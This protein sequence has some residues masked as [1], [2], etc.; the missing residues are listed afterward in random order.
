MEAWLKAIGTP[1]AKVWNEVIW[2]PRIE[3]DGDFAQVWAPFAFYLDTTLS[4]CGVDA[5]H[6]IR[7]GNGQWKIFHLAD[8]HR[9]NGCEIPKEVSDRIK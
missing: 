4:H 8:T 7:D 5:F 1:H 9:V 6:L 3:V 2:S